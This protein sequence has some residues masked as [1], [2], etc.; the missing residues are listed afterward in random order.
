[1]PSVTGVQHQPQHSSLMNIPRTNKT[2]KGKPK[3][4][5]HHSVCV[6]FT[7]N[8]YQVTQCPCVLIL[9]PREIQILWSQTERKTKTSALNQGKASEMLAYLVREH[10]A[11]QTRKI[12]KITTKKDKKKDDRSSEECD[13]RRSERLQEHIIPIYAQTPTSFGT[14][15]STYF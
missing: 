1:M 6:V 10:K 11:S 4:E 3:R 7:L 8:R 15:S 14:S 2:K 13:A 9:H 5:G 12:R